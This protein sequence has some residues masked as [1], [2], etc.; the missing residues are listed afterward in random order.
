MSP[1]AMETWGTASAAVP[2]W[3]ASAAA[4]ALGRVGGDQAAEALEKS[5]VNASAG[6]RPALAQGC[7]LCAEKYLAGGKAGRA[8]QLYDLVRRAAVPKQRMIEATRGAILARQSAGLNLLLETLR[9]P[10][11]AMFDIGLHTARE[12]DGRAVTEALLA[13]N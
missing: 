10:D 13:L 4:V 11:K 2:L 7:I 8:G 1:N 3:F 5:L 6:L 12:L 9:S